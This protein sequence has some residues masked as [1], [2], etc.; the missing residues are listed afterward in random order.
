MADELNVRRPQCKTTLM[1]D[2]L[3]GKRPQWKTT[4]MEDNINGRRPKCKT[5]FLVFIQFLQ[6][7]VT[8]MSP[9][10]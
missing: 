10:D 9:K 8:G 4:S 6:H 5:T 2:N 1:E 7:Y 3:H